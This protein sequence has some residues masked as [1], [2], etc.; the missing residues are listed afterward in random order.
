[1]TQTRFFKIIGATLVAGLLTAAPLSAATFTFNAEVTNSNGPSMTPFVP[2]LPPIGTA[3]TVELEIFDADPTL[4]IFDGFDVRI[5]AE[6]SVDVPG[7]ISGS[8][9]NNPNPA[10]FFQVTDSYLAFGSYGPTSVAEDNG[11]FILPNAR[12]SFRIDYGAPVLAT[13]V[14]VGDLVTALSAPGASGY[15]SHELEGQPGFIFTRVEF[16]ASTPQVP[17]P[18]SAWFLMVGLAGLGVM[19]RRHS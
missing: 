3:G 7:W 13:P 4:T 2:S 6:A 11:A 16:P 18:A 14:T 1:M 12:H 17:L 9:L 15:F 19:R 5:V 8:M 10:D